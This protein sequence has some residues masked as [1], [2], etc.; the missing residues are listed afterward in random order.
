MVIRLECQQ[1][2][3]NV[4]MAIVMLWNLLLTKPMMYGPACPP[5]L[6]M[7]LIM[8]IPAVAAVPDR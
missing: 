3:A 5:K 4:S 6:P 8:A 2:P 7:E 1:K